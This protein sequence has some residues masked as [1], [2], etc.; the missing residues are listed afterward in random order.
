MSFT[1]IK[2]IAV[3][4]IAFLWISCKHD[5]AFQPTPEPVVVD[6]L[7]DPNEVYFQNDVLPILISNCTQSGCHNEQDQAEDIVLTSYDQLAASMPDFQ[8]KNWNKNELI[9]VLVDSDPEDRMPLD[10]PPLP[11]AQIDL[12]K[13]WIEQGAKNSECNENST[14][15]CDTTS[16][17]FSTFVQPL[18]QQ[19]CLGCHNGNN[20]QGNVSLSTY[21]SVQTVALNGKLYGSLI[22]ASN[23]MPKGGQRLNDCNLAKVKKW[24]N[25]GAKND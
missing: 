9:E 7:C 15:N 21:S 19:R 16:V 5:P 14:G 17:K 18:I 10:A 12:L 24:I 23:W 3:L 22:A 25:D 8:D 2:I 1:S 13:R 6:T 4:T 20:P 11:T